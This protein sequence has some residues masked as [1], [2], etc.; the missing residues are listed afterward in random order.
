MTHSNRH[1]DPA[2]SVRAVGCVTVVTMTDPAR[3]NVLARR[4]VQELVAAFDEAEADGVTRC[5]VL[6]GEGTAFCAGAEL[7]ALEASASGDFSGVEDVYRGFLRVL[8]STLATIAVVNG[9]AVGAGLNLALACDLRLATHQ[10][11]FDSRFAKLRLIPGGGHSWLLERAVGRETAVAMTVFGERL[12]AA[13]A[14]AAGL[15]W[16]LYDTAEGA[17]SAAVELGGRLQGQDP[18][19]VAALTHLAR[20]A[21]ARSSHAEALDVERY[22]QRWSTSRPGFLDGVRRMRDAVEARPQ[23]STEQHAR[24]EPAKPSTRRSE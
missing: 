5:V 8:S 19:F 16:R 20:T 18:Q 21:P 22:M 13:A 12:D 11:S 15:V 9:P 24:S 6:A 14:A 17:T 1:A 23:P 10:A 4:M 7:S 2:V 3:R